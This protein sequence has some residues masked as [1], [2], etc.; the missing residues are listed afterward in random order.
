IMIFP[1]VYNIVKL[2]PYQYVYY[3]SLTGGVQGAFRRYEM[4]YWATAYKETMDYVNQNAAPNS[5]IVVV[6][7]ARIASNYARPDLVIDSF[8]GI[9]PE[10]MDE[11]D[12]GI[13]TTRQNGD[14]LVQLA[15]ET[16]F[17]VG[18]ENAVF[19]IVRKLSDQ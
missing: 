18:K 1:G 14:L 16:V 9:L 12:Y 15:G 2:H 7:A 19:A 17:Q 13:I 3:N 11:Y 6:G 4:D 8:F 10:D 5:K